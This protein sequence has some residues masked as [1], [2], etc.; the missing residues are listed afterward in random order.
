MKKG[1]LLALLK[2]SEAVDSRSL[3]GK[4][5]D[6]IEDIEEA[7]QA[8]F[9]RSAIVAALNKKG[10]EVTVRQLEQILYRQRRKTAENRYIPGGMT[11]TVHKPEAK[12]AQTPTKAT[13]EY[14]SSKSGAALFGQQ[15]KTTHLPD[16]N[17]SITNSENGH[18]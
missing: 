1:D 6:H 3:A 14:S 2:E 5:R 7:L 9:K 18:E 13:V 4:V 12:P 11:E 8:G 15:T 17:L 16:A 10:I